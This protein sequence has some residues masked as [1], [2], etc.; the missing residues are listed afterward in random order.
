MGDTAYEVQRL[1]PTEGNLTKFRAKALTTNYELDYGTKYR[2][3]KF[4]NDS[5]FKL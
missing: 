5:I 3:I 2:F 4:S 1:A